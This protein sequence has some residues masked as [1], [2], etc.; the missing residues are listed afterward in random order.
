[1][2][3][4]RRGRLGGLDTVVRCRD[5]H[6]YTTIWVPGVSVKSFRLLWWRVQMCPVGRHWSV[7]TP[8]VVADLTPVQAA[9]AASIHDIRIP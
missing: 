4:H 2:L 9:Q 8:A 3:A 5:G 1:M 6:L 7:V